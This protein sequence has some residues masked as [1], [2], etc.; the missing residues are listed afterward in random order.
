VECDEWFYGCPK[1]G[2]QRF[3]SLE[4]V[5]HPLSREHFAD[6]DLVGPKLVAEGLGSSSSSQARELVSRWFHPTDAN[7][8]PEGHLR[9]TVFAANPGMD[10]VSAKTDVG[11]Y[12]PRKPQ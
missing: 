9:C 6:P 5:L 4:G 3:D 2:C 11:G 1:I 10:L 12:C 7:A 8:T